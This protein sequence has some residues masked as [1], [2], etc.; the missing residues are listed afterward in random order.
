MTTRNKVL[1]VAVGFVAIAILQMMYLPFTQEAVLASV[2]VSPEPI[3]KVGGFEISNSLITAWIAM[4]LLIL[5]AF[6]ATRNMQLA[7]SG[8]QNAFE[9]VIEA[10][11]GLAESVAG[12]RGRQFFTIA[13]TIFLFVMTSNLLGLVP[14]SGPIGILTIDAKHY[15]PAGIIT[16]DVPQIFAHHEAV[17]GEAETHAPTDKAKTEKLDQKAAAALA[18][19]FRSPSTD[20]NF[21]LV[22]ALISVVMTQVYGVQALGFFGY[23]G[24]FLN[25]GR[26]VKFFGGLLRGK[27]RIGTFLYGLL[28]VF[29][30]L[31]ELISELG[32][33]LSFTFRLF[34]NI[35]AGEVVLLVMS[36]LFLALP[37][38]FYG[39]E[40]F[41]GVIQGFVFCVL[42]LA[43]MS[44]A[45]TPHHAEEEQH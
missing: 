19:F 14:G 12:A 2:S 33:I 26:L 10:I 23:V 18:P 5:L 29:V 39:L 15:V 42:T 28:D 44:I 34:G 24:K 7:P 17:G 22:L 31:V 8:L 21:P 36:F 20:I 25:F 4:L 40:V 35:F 41:V 16:F 32:K 43:F 38:A 27:V 1:I 37:L 30:G 45:T 13:A 11:L 6:F 3:L 9:M